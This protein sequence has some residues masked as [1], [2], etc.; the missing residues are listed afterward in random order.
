MNIFKTIAGLAFSSIL[1]NSCAQT[2]TKVE[3]KNLYDITINSLE[4][5][6]IDLNDFKGKF[7]LFVNVASECG[8]TPQYKELQELHNKYKNQLIVIGVPCNQFGKQE[9]GNATEIKSFCQKNYGVEFLI[10]EK[11]DVKGESQHPL[12]SWLTLKENNGNKG[13]TVKW[14]FQKYLVGK[15]GK[16]IDFFYSV[17]SP[18]SEKITSHFSK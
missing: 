8:F 3:A 1:F 7:I 2:E 13:S 11:I 17:T 10:T 6:A 9:P 5:D 18:T 12:Y 14:N 16:L 4:G 15:D